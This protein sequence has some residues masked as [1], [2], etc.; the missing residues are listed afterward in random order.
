MRVLGNEN[1][2]IK[3]A[4]RD[5]GNAIKTLGKTAELGTG[6]GATFKHFFECISAYIE[7]ISKCG[8]VT[9]KPYKIGKIREKSYL[10]G[11]LALYM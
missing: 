6:A 11:E 10:L 2:N 9:E 7:C 3:A 5:H 8:A 1:H 4:R